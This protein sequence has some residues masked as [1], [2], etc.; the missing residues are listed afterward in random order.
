MNSKLREIPDKEYE[1]FNFI[2]FIS[3]RIFYSTVP[4]YRVWKQYSHKL[5]KDEEDFD[6]FPAPLYRRNRVLEKVS[7]Y[8]SSFLIDKPSKTKNQ[9]ID[10][11]VESQFERTA[12]SGRNSEESKLFSYVFRKEDINDWYLPCLHDVSSL[13]IRKDSLIIQVKILSLNQ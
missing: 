13:W 3:R 10:E 6:H 12:E 2:Y 8:P 1:K 7:E 4:N 11:F 5:E 9:Y